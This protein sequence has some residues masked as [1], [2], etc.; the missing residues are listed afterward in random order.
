MKEIKKN[1]MHS[2]FYDIDEPEMEKLMKL[3]NMPR[4]GVIKVISELREGANEVRQLSNK[5]AKK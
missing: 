1:Q 2:L 3:W 4:H 5:G